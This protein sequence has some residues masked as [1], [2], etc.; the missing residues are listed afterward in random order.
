MPSMYPEQRVALPA[1]VLR[2]TFV[3]SQLLTAAVYRGNLEAALAG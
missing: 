3:I 2:K 1:L